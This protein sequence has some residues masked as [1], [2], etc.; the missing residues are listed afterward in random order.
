M[1][2]F[3]CQTAELKLVV[4]PMIIIILFTRG[5]VIIL[6]LPVMSFLM[7]TSTSGC[8]QLALHRI[9]SLC[10]SKFNVENSLIALKLSSVFIFCMSASNKS[11]ISCS[12]HTLLLNICSGSS[13][14]MNP[15]AVDTVFS[16]SLYYH[17]RTSHQ[18]LQNSQ[19]WQ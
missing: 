11:L 12:M 14:E 6:Q 19:D 13:A 1:V 9:L 16:H 15:E 17:C 2:V 10:H 4:A 5:N 3:E 8:S 18:K 7:K